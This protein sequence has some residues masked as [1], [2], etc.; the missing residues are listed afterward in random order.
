MRG[1]LALLNRHRPGH[2]QLSAYFELQRSLEAIGHFTILPFDEKAAEFFASLRRQFPRSGT[3]DLQIAAICLAH[4]AVLLTRN[5]VDFE[6]VP[7]LRVENW[8][9]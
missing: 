9:D 3:M 7:G 5:L 6:K 8:L 1:W 2:D 4:D